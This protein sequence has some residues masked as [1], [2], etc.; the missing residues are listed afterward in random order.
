MT[1]VFACVCGKAFPTKSAAAGL[2]ASTGAGYAEAVKD[3]CSADGVSRV[4]EAVREHGIDR[5]V[6][7][8]CPAIER[9]GLVSTI[10]SAAGIPVP[11]RRVPSI[12]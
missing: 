9:A 12:E 5:I 11:A 1:G 3:L 4:I 8:G 2:K 6:L 10:A 7:A